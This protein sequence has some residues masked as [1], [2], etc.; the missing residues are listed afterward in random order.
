MFSDLGHT[1]C[2]NTA[3]FFT[4]FLFGIVMFAELLLCSVLH[5]VSVTV[6][7]KNHNFKGELKFKF[8][9]SP[10]NHY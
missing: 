8:T 6:S 3:K 4:C 10:I 5:V 2:K 7:N 9:I 1:F